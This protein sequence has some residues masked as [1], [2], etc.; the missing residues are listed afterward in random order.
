MVTSANDTSASSGTPLPSRFSDHDR[1]SRLEVTN[2]GMGVAFIGP[3]I[4]MDSDAASIRTDRPI[5]PSC[6]V[7]YFEVSIVSGGVHGYLAH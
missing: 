2:D 4:G 1:E 5:P 3:A 7:Y 6:G